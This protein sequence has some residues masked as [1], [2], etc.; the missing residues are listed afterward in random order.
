MSIR[1]VILFLLLLFRRLSVDVYQNMRRRLRSTAKTPITLAGVVG[2]DEH[3]CASFD[4]MLNFSPQNNRT[5]LFLIP[6][7]WIAAFFHLMKICCNNS[8]RAAINPLMLEFFFPLLRFDRSKD[9]KYFALWRI[10]C[11]IVLFVCVFWPVYYDH[12]IWILYEWNTKNA[13]LEKRWNQTIFKLSFFSSWRQLCKSCFI[14]WKKIYGGPQSTTQ[15]LITAKIKI[16]RCTFCV[17][18]RGE[19]FIKWT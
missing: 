7:K 15:T 5:V 2:F 1:F 4:C 11:R 6:N 14:T 13:I 3:V 18:V 16:N 10:F 19:R 17:G 8:R 9:T 12:N